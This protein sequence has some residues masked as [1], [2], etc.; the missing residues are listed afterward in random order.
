MQITIKRKSPTEYGAYYNGVTMYAPTKVG[1]LKLLVKYL[2]ESAPEN[3]V[4]LE[5]YDGYSACHTTTKLVKY[6][7]TKPEALA[8]LT[9]ALETKENTRS[10]GL[11]PPNSDSSFDN[12][13]TTYKE[14]VKAQFVKSETQRLQD[15]NE[16][17][18]KSIKEASALKSKLL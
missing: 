2:E 12:S 16:L 13:N 8:N 4:I 7:S 15:L 11:V 14:T 18:S 6:G 3:I 10:K 9:E 1:A 17:I 5:C